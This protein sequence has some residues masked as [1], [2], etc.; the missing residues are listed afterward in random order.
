MISAC[1]F[2]SFLLLWTLVIDTYILSQVVS[3]IGTLVDLWYSNHKIYSSTRMFHFLIKRGE[4]TSPV[5]REFYRL[6]FSAPNKIKVREFTNMS[7]LSS[8]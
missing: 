5:T 6:L 3:C 2:R 8:R 1:N 4:I 7:L